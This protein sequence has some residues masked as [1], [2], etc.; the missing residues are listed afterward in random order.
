M[1]FKII[2]CLL[3]KKKIVK[4]QE[5][6]IHNTPVNRL[7]IKCSIRGK[8][9]MQLTITLLKPREKILGP[10]N[11]LLKKTSFPS[12]NSTEGESPFLK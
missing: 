9:I 7:L 12:I 6:L 8:E 10:R 11:N 4:F 1:T 3:I 5:V 2:S